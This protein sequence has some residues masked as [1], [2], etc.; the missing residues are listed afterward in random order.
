MAP[1]PRLRQ[2]VASALRANPFYVDRQE[3]DLALRA[4]PG[5]FTFPMCWVLL[6]FT[7]SFPKDHAVVFYLSAVVGLATV[8]ARIRLCA[9]RV[10][11]RQGSHWRSWHFGLA[12]SMGLNWGLVFAA[13]A[14]FYHY[15]GWV[16]LLVMLIAVAVCC[17]YVVAFF[18]DHILARALTIALLAPGIA[19]SLFVSDPHAL[20][21]AIM[22]FVMLA[23][24]WVQIETLNRSY[25][26]GH[27]EHARAEAAG[28]AK[29]EFLANMSHE[30]R[31]PL[32]GMMGML[33]LVLQSPLAPEQGQFLRDAYSASQALLR[34]LNDILELS[35]IEAGE[36]RPE[37][38]PFRLREVLREVVSTFRLK[39]AG[40]GIGLA[41]SGAG[42][43][44]E[45][46]LGD[47]GRLRQVLFN[48]VGN[49]VKFT[50]RGVISIDAGASEGDPELLLFE[51][52]DTGIGIAPEK[53]REIFNPFSQADGGT[54]R[55]FGG[56]G[57]GLTISA[58]LV[59]LMGGELKVE[60]QPGAGSRFYFALRLPAA[61]MPAGESRANAAAAESL[62][63]LRVLVA[64]DN[65]LNCRLVEAILRR[66][67]HSVRVSH[68][69]REAFDAFRAERFNL[70]LMDMQMP[71]VDGL[72]ATRLIRRWEMETGA[73]RVPVMA[74][75][76]NVM[77][78]DRAACLDSGM[79]GHLAKP[80]R[81][82]ELLG[83]IRSLAA[84]VD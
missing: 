5:L 58:R 82:E 14:A 54:T 75:T 17:A 72:E 43:A 62:P 50:G 20:H 36:M 11:G 34:L 41:V 47:P 24:C 70:V 25:W 31:T 10:A 49:A 42:Q 37:R 7:T 63:P 51:V 46:V 1:R 55:K 67:G 83:T 57:L 18:A 19:T 21:I 84:P 48:L 30:I 23:F 40:K 73:P 65:P 60:S 12:V 81:I 38:I 4:R 44:P 56:T 59:K 2:E 32:N 33:Q 77:P 39:A 3:R 16:S 69:G 74:L 9:Q 64:E 52:S 26:L 15:Q 53:Q 68:D 61:E 45:V 8:A 22:C 27:E 71:N 78:A 29:S 35:K 13:T 28:R 6:F 80:L 66:Q 79:D 76:A